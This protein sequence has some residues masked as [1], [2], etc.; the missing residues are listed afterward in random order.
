MTRLGVA[1]L[2]FWLCGIA[3]MWAAESRRPAEP[4]QDFIYMLAVA[5]PALLVAVWIRGAWIMF[6]DGVE[7][8]L[9]FRS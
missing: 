6:R 2:C 9:G 1:T 5:W 4:G 3:A 7:A 8:A